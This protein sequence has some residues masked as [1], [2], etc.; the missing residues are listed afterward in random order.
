LKVY[1]RT[2]CG[3]IC[4]F[5]YLQDLVNKIPFAKKIRTF[6]ADKYLRYIKYVVLLIYIIAN[7]TMR[8]TMRSMIMPPMMSIIT[9]A[10]IILTLI[11]FQRPFCKYV[12]PAGAI[13][14]IF[15]KTTR[16]KYNVDMKNVLNVKRV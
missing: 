15:N 13:F 11:I 8:N 3:K 2:F 1:G 6:K 7:V 9:G 10:I 14:S 16:H 4:P 12:C 5:G